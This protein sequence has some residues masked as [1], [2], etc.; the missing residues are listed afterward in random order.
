MQK[1]DSGEEE[2]VFE[3]YD[4]DLGF[5]S[6][7]AEQKY[8][9]DYVVES[10]K[11]AKKI[12]KQTNLDWWLTTP[13]KVALAFLLGYYDGDGSY[14]GGRSATIV[15]SSKQFLEHIKELFGIKNK[16]N[17]RVEAGTEI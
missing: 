12:S 3:F 4:E 5:Q 8:V 14:G 1:K 10:V 2:F 13:G 6:S 16:V 11:E 15:A 9:P 17:P 7:K